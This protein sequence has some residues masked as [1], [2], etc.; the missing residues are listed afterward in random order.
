MLTGPIRGKLR[1]LLFQ[2][3][4]KDQ[5]KK[6]QTSLLTKPV[7]TLASIYKAALRMVHSSN[8]AKNG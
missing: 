6:G 4:K 1:G 7:S 5:Q 8:L 3:P 2:L